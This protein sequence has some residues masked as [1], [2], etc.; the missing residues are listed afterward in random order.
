MSTFT[1]NDHVVELLRVFPRRLARRG[2]EHEPV[3]QYL[4]FDGIEITDAVCARLSPTSMGYM[5][6]EDLRRDLAKAWAEKRLQGVPR[7]ELQ[8]RL[9]RARTPFARQMIERAIRRDEYKFTPCEDPRMVAIARAQHNRMQPEDRKILSAVEQVYY[10][11]HAA[12]TRKLHRRL[13]ALGARGR[14]AAQ[15]LRAQKASSRAKNYCA[16]KHRAKLYTVQVIRLR[17]EGRCNR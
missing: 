11:S 12:T 13:E 7:E 6:V 1:Q 4:E 15:L 10:G 17:A 5:V 3:R 8:R 16:A 2:R 9:E 14:I